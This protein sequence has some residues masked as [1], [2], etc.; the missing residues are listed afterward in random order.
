[1]ISLGGFLN[2]TKRQWIALSAAA[3]WLVGVATLIVTKPPIDLAESSAAFNVSRAIQLIAAILLGLSLVALINTRQKNNLFQ[4]IVGSSALLVLAIVSLYIYWFVISDWTCN[5]HQELVIKGSRYN[6]EAAKIYQN[7]PDLDCEHIL[8]DALGQAGRVWSETQLHH[9][10]MI[11]VSLYTLCV[12]L[13][14]AS[15][16]SVLQ[17][18]GITFSGDDNE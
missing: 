12:M 4:W 13:L 5:Y 14:S 10:H 11:A 17:V 7:N 8:E 6:L 16:V 1:M 15:I 3:V 2:S 9:R 18:V